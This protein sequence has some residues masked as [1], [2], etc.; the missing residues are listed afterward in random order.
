MIVSY[1]VV[2]VFH[3]EDQS[4]DELLA[5]YYEGKTCAPWIEFSRQGAIDYVREH[6]PEFT[7]QSDDECWKHMSTGYIT[8]EAGNL[9]TTSNPDS[10]WDWWTEGGRWE[11]FLRLK[12]GERANS[13]RIKDIDF[14]LDDE[15]YSKALRFWDIVVEHK[16]L[17]SDE[18]KPFLLYSEDYYEP[19]IKIEKLMHADKRNFQHSRY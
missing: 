14:S 12:N 17:E 9:Y 10:K 4:V 1:F 18:E 6:Y 2:A 16:P 19:F 15:V 8:D 11:G 5:P 7:Q 3:E 13:A